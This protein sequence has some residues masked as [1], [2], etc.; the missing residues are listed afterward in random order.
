MKNLIKAIFSVIW[1]IIWRVLVAIG[2]LGVV[3][4]S[5]YGLGKLL[6]KYD[7]M[8]VVLTVFLVIVGGGLALLGFGY[9]VKERY[10]K[11]KAIDK[12]N[13]DHADRN[14]NAVRGL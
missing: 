13:R 9:A 8:Y 2:T 3:M 14:G 7:F 10:E 5:M 12:W 6:E 1:S 11:Y 4:L